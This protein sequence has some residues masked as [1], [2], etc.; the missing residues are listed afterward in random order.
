MA[1]AS[2]LDPRRR[3]ARK[4]LATNKVVPAV[5]AVAAAAPTQQ[6]FN[7]LRAVVVELRAALVEN[8]VVKSA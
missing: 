3:E 2:R 4:S 7:D 1:R 5:P 8:G 6:N